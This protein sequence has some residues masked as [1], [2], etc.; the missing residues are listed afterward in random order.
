MKDYSFPV[1][2]Y[3]I[4]YILDIYLTELQYSIYHLPQLQ[5]FKRHNLVKIDPMGEAFDPLYHEALYQVADTEAA[6]GTVCAVVQ[7]GYTLHERS[8]RAAKVGVVKET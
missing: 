6:P 2:G 4:V 8:L 7:S 1:D 3:I 5:V